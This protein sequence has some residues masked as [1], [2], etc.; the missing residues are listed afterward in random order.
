MTTVS[1]RA[2]LALAGLSA[3]LLNLCFP[4]AGPLP[5]WRSILA[6]VGAVPLLVALLARE[7]GERP[8]NRPL[9]RGFLTGWC[10]G[11]LWYAVNCYWIYQ[12]MYLYGGLP[13]AAAVG[14]LLLFSLI[15][16]LYYGLFGWLIAFARRSSGGLA[17]PLV[18]A[19]FLWTA[20][21]LLDA[22]LIRVP[23]DQ[24]GYSQESN[25][26]LSSIAPWT[27]V[28]GI[29]FLLLVVNAL[30]AGGIV[31]GQRRL[32]MAGAGLLVV[33]NAGLLW[34]PAPAPTEATAVLLQENLN[35]QQD[36]AWAGTIWDP[37]TGRYVDEWDVN[38]AHFVELSKHTCTPYIAG[39]PE[40]GAPVV[41][42]HCDHEGGASLIV[43]PEAPSA[44]TEHDPRFRELI[45]RMTTGTRAAAIVGNA[46]AD[47]R[48]GHVDLYNAASVFAPDGALLGRYAKIHLVPW[49]EYIPFQSF[50]SFAHGITH[51]AGR[52]THGWRRS[53]FRVK[54]H[55]YGIFICYESIFADEIRQFALNGAEVL[56]NISDDGWYGDTSA[57][58][59]HL[60]M[61]RMRAIE[62]RRWLL[63]DTNTGVTAAIDPYGRLTQSAPRHVFTSL[64]VQYGF[65]DDLTFY[66][67]Y[68]DVFA[69]ACGILSI[70][71]LAG[72]V[73]RTIRRRTE[74]GRAS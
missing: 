12:T 50:F 5:V 63:R 46:A 58:W 67:R 17:A 48:P 51:N 4:L 9:L 68:G 36:N 26:A 13:V 60:N 54:G 29:T 15:M 1:S 62:N 35:V 32:W 37:K 33:M 66:T 55:H 53:V 47:V 2:R 7:E 43:W 21:D 61:A 30:I 19:P 69:L 20:I 49:G 45:R 56:V 64:A 6:W 8:P 65:R 22:H 71:M 52:F 70:A 72:G 40:T 23:W 3:V 44:L 18:L 14:I 34:H 25:A 16:G 28:Y 42:P 73:R 39:M 11:V 41:T 31:L 10:F 59:Q 57:P 24:L 27:G 38:T 74:R